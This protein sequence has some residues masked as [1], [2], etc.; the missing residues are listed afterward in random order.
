MMIA[1]GEENVYSFKP[2]LQKDEY[3]KWQKTILG[4]RLLHVGLFQRTS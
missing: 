4:K 2:S 3:T 1:F